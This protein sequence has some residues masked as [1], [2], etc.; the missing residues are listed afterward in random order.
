[1][2]IPSKEGFAER[3]TEVSCCHYLC[4]NQKSLESY[5]GGTTTFDMSLSHSSATSLS[6][7]STSSSSSTTT[8]W[9]SGIVRGRPDRPGSVK[10]G[11]NSNVGA[12]GA[13]STGPVARKN[14]WRGVLFKYGPKPIQVSAKKIYH[15]F[16]E[17]D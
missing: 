4:E 7:T 10:M 1:M 9:L 13:D 11:S 8:S 17:F 12:G 14:Q 16:N 6:S 15:L 2:S 3:I 5:G